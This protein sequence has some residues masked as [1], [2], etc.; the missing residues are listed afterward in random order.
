[1]SNAVATTEAVYDAEIVQAT[2]SRDLVNTITGDDHDTRKRIF[3]AVASSKSISDMIGKDVKV[4]NIVQQWIVPE[5]KVN[6]ATGEV[7]Q[8]KP[9]IRTTLIGPDGEPAYSASSKGI[10]NSVD[11]ILD[12]LGQ[13]AS[14]ENDFEVF[15]IHEEGKKPNS[16]FTLE[17]VS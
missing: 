9:Y 11:Q 1:M 6:E 7:K 17:L 4:A 16:Y 15:R 10:V 14:W 13:P 3:K 12:I 2:P 8:D 5:P